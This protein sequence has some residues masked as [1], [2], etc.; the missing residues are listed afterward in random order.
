MAGSTGGSGACGAAGALL[1]REAL[2]RAAAA[3]RGAQ[4]GCGL[5]PSASSAAACRHDGSVGRQPRSWMQ[6]CLATTRSRC[7]QLALMRKARGYLAGNPPVNSRSSAGTFRHHLA[8]RYSP[9]T[10]H[11]DRCRGKMLHACTWQCQHQKA[12]QRDMVFA[13]NARPA[14]HLGT[15][16]LLLRHG[17]ALSLARSSRFRAPLRTL[18][19]RAQEEVGRRRP[20]LSGRRFGWLRLLLLLAAALGVWRGAW[21]LGPSRLHLSRCRP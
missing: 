18:L 20:R 19:R 3:G 13:T 9:M 14:L 10:Q 16:A 11:A 1:S 6:P 15:L 21:P 7:M 5:H 8:C 2:P 17:C 12:C 4:N